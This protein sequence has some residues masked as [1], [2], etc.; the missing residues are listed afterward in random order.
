LLKG[1]TGFESEK[2]VA[3]EK[4]RAAMKHVVIVGGGFAGLSCAR[5]LGESSQVRVTLIDKNNYQQFQ[6]LLYQVASAIL[7]P[8][9]AAF[10]LRGVL[11]RHPNVDVKMA[12][13][14]SADLKTRTVKTLD[15]PLEAVTVRLRHSK[16]H[17][18]D[19]AD[20]ES[21]E[22]MLDRIE[23]DLEFA[24]RIRGAANPRATLEAACDCR[25][26]PSPPHP[27]LRNRHSLPRAVSNGAPPSDLRSKEV[28][29]R[30]PM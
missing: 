8:S 14:V 16:I 15:W 17:A 30:D 7:S 23:S 9:N 12:E 19:C 3:N 24:T 20:C 11:R 25:E 26:M 18:A 29:D 27:R 13:V 4:E 2:Q 1:R 6:P 28:V 10:A 21:K 22:G 5:K